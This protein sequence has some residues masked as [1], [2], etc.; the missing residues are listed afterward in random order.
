MRKRL[1]GTPASAS[2]P[3]EPMQTRD[4]QPSSAARVSLH[5]RAGWMLAARAR[6]TRRRRPPCE[7]RALMPPASC[8]PPAQ[9]PASRAQLAGTPAQ[10]TEASQPRP[11]LRHARLQRAATLLDGVMLRKLGD[12][13]LRRA[14]RLQPQQRARAA[15]VTDV[16]RAAAQPARPRGAPGRVAPS[17]T[18][19]RAML[20]TAMRSL[21]STTR[22]AKVESPARQLGGRASGA[23]GPRRRRGASLRGETRF[24][25]GRYEIS[26]IR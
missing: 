7:P 26:Q 1:L 10:A 24:C 17:V 25:E 21:A 16:P 11:A 2:A 12:G 15:K 3:A 22:E 9:P 18:D 23:L 13:A 19:A 20:H 14:E 8:A 6:A 5:T 4:A